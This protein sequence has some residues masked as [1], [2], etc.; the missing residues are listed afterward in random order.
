MSR[1]SVITEVAWVGGGRGTTPVSAALTPCEN[2]SVAAGLPWANAERG[3]NPDPNSRPGD[4]SDG[5]KKAQQLGP[6]ALTTSH[7]RNTSI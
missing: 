6:A 7:L 4:T 2:R 5:A 3:K 1:F